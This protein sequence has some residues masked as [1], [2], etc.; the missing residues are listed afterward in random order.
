MLAQKDMIIDLVSPLIARE[1]HIAE[2]QN[3][4]FTGV[5]A[6]LAVNDNRMKSFKR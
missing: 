1:K 2:Y 4:K 5:G 3:G 6:T